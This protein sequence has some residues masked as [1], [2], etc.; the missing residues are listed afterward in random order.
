VFQIFETRNARDVFP[1]Q[2]APQHDHQTAVSN[3]QI[4]RNHGMPVRLVLAQSSETGTRRRDE[5]SPVSKHRGNGFI[6]MAIEE[7][8]TKNLAG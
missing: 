4:S 7:L 2:Q 6:D 3:R 1:S 5:K 8:D